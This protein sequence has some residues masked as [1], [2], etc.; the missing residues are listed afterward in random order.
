MASAKQTNQLVGQ[1]TQIPHIELLDIDGTGLVSEI[2]IV[3]RTKDGTIHYIDVSK[4]P[5]LDK[6][7]LRK[8]L[9]SPHA[10]KY[11]LWELL[12][13]SKLSNG[14]NALDFF[15][16]NFVKIKR[17][18]GAKNVTAPES[19]LNVAPVND[20]VIGTDFANPEEAKLDSDG[21]L[22]LHTDTI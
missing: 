2:A 7:R 10:D 4:L 21:M 19:I 22:N 12:S 16:N 11:E 3:K 8:I 20:T 6:G 9:S 14:L 15:H 5:P 1:K 17:P 18:L 13:Q